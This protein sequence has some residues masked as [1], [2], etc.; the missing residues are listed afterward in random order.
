MAVA[1]EQDKIS[2]WSPFRYRVFAV[3]WT[4]TLLSNIGGWMHDVG[5]GWLMTTL[6]PSPLLVSLVQAATTL[7]VFLLALPAGALADVVDRKRL[8]L[9]AKVY[10][11]VIAAGMGIVVLAGSMTPVVLLLFTVALGA[12]TALINPAWQ[13]IVPQLV[14]RSQLAS[15]VALNSVG[16][17]VSRA[18]GPALAG[19]AIATLGLASPFLFNAVSFLAVIGA[20]LWWTPP[21]AA[22][23]Q[24]PAERWVAAMRAGVRYARSSGPL[25]A[26]LLRAVGFLLFASAYWALLPLVARQQLGGGAELYGVLVTCIG[27]G[28]VAGAT[29]LPRLRKR[30][31][32]SR[33][34]VLSAV[35]TAA[36]LVA[37]ALLREPAVVAAVCVLA[38]ATWIAALSSFNVSAQMSLPDWVRARGLALFSAVQFG[39]LALGSTLWGQ[40]AAELGIPSALLIA[41][42]GALLAGVLM[43][44]VPLQSAGELDLTPAAHWPQ[45]VVAGSIEPDRGPVMVTVEYRV[46]PARAAD[47]LMALDALAQ[48]RRRDGAYG[49][50]VFRDAAEPER[51]LEYFYEESWTEHLRHHA[52]V[53]QADRDVEARVRGFHKGSAPPRVTHYLAADAATTAAA[54]APGADGSLR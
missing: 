35:G 30:Y 33:L 19:V 3:L 36:V 34:V 18:I 29:L 48:E 13:A 25:K 27:A 15:A 21:A 43:A 46:D 7:P 41:A 38:G 49:W 23:R 20:L 37:F 50:C 5:A 26:T 16:I 1:V 53:T 4:A 51:F 11:T 42:G 28:A 47:F 45:P 6:H 22:P 2:A 52:R 24:L 12:G 54:P 31:G 32:S 40:T 17:N 9:I 8:L 44:R 39:S 10:M 14:P